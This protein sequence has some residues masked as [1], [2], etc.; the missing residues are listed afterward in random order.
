MPGSYW[1]KVL[2]RRVGRRRA[3][4]M[5]GGSAAA[6][7]FL[8]A[9]GSDDDGGG[10]ST[11]ATGGGATGGGSTGGGATGGGAT[12]ATGGGATGA[13]GGGASSGLLTPPA[14]RFSEAVRGGVFKDFMNSEP[15]SL[16]PIN[17]QAGLNVQTAEV[18][19]TLV[20]ETPGY[21]EPGAYELEGDLAESFEV[22]PDGLQLIFKLRPNA[23]WH[24]IAPISGRAVDTEDIL[25]SLERHAEIAPL[26]A[27]VW[28]AVTGGGFALAPSAPDETTVVI[29]LSEPV[30]YAINYFASFGSYT[31]QVLMY[32][33]EAA[34]E[35]V[36]D[37]RQQQIGTGPLMLKEHE[38]SVRYVYERNPDYWDQDF[39]LFDTLE[40]PI[41]SEYAARLAQLIAGEIYST[42]DRENDI[43]RATDIRSILNDQ[44]QLNLY[45]ASTFLSTSVM[46]FGWLPLGD[47]PYLDERVRQ[48]ISMSVDRDLDNDVRYNVAEFEELG[49]PVT[50]VW[51]SHLSAYDEFRAAGWWLDP[52]GS[53][54][55]EGAKYFEYN[56]PEAKKL[57]EAAG[58]PDGFDVKFYY[59]NT[60]QFDRQAV[61]EPF[62]FYLQELGLN[63]IDSGLT[64]Y[65]QGYIPLDRDASGEYDG[66]GYHSVTGTIPSIVS[67][68]SN[69]VA[70]HLPSSGVTF[71]GYSGDGSGDKNG[72][73]A[74]IEI[75]EKAKVEQD[76]EARKALIHEAQQYLAVKQWSLREPGGATGF[77]LAWPTVQGIQV[78]QGGDPWDRYKIWLDPT[79]APLA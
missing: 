79:Q 56:L 58:Y 52:Q 65:T 21:L 5:T 57:L 44:P 8:A 33:K 6:A 28:N 32:P 42:D 50:S 31:G 61:V 34:D 45:E 40:Q 71:H 69:M 38:P 13:T 67:P 30:A 59:P 55:G 46:T 47:N 72:D 78:Y 66:I 51:N 14:D 12:G 63:V 9:C 18:Y 73:P 60:P 74:L 35:N 77:W 15:N 10:G 3:L 39:I 53:E 11:A 2:N 17:P 4:A 62:F 76:V 68:T 16:D 36:F 25:F 70:E 48:A 26:R 54:L 24:N 20:K 1:T 75:L 49:L 37:I 64:D 43:A 27:L 22:S 19:S 29:P 41:I 23:K 7:A